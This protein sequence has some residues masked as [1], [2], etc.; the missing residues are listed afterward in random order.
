LWDLAQEAKTL[1]R[2]LIAEHAIACGVA[3][4]HLAAAAKASHARNL[5]AYAEHLA[6]R[7]GYSH[8][9]YVPR[10]EMPSLVASHRYFGGYFDSD[11]FHLHPLSY[12]LG[13]AAAAETAGA[14][15]FENTRVIAIDRGKKLRLS[16]SGGSLECDYAVVACN[17]YIER[18]VPEI[19]NRILPIRNYIVA[20][21]PLGEARARALIPSRAAVA[22]TKF[23]LDYYRL[24]SDNRLIFGGGETYGTGP[25]DIGEFVRPY[26]ERTFPQMKGIGIDYAW[27][28]TLAITAPRLP[29]VG[30]LGPNV[31]FAQGYSGQGVAIA[32][33]MGK[34]IADAIAGEAEKFAVYE[35]LAVP[36]IP[37]GAMLRRPLLTLGMLW[38]AFRDRLP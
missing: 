18:L 35:S 27:E 20:S 2:S 8:G 9:R 4:G 30:R 19:E 10:Q 26:L 1:V 32:T 13:L 21:E 33:Q 6:T 11:A 5:S 16:T 12:A 38:Y 28:G 7:Y 15:I 37:G 25:R 29:H 31:Y 23:V 34:L 24:S 17:G 3:P 36:A 14:K 22:D